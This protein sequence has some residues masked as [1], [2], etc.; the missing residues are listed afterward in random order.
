MN[1]C[2]YIKDVN[3]NHYLMPEDN[4]C[5]LVKKIRSIQSI[6]RYILLE[7][8]S[9]FLIQNITQLLIHQTSKLDYVHDNLC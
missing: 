7:I 2:I 5:N 3:Q 9:I 4:T 6:H 1:T 8:L